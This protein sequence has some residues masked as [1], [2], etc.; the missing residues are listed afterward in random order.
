MCTAWNTRWHTDFLVTRPSINVNATPSVSN[1]L[2]LTTYISPTSS[3]PFQPTVSSSQGYTLN[4]TVTISAPS[5]IM[6]AEEQLSPIEK[7]AQGALNKM[8]SNGSLESVGVINLECVRKDIAMTFL[9]NHTFSNIIK[10]L[11][12][13]SAPLKED[14]ECGTA[15]LQLRGMH[16][17]FDY[18]I[19]GTEDIPGNYLCY[20]EQ[21]YYSLGNGSLNISDEFEYLDN[22]TL[23]ATCLLIEGKSNLRKGQRN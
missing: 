3:S 13:P 9:K 22:T 4:E 5:E 7:C 17:F 23:F 15:T 6:K 16:Q 14:F 10:Y 8:S 18:E 21:I 2:S 12:D 20:G 1:E 11:A 19:N